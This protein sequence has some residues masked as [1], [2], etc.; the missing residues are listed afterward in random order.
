MVYHN[1]Y[2]FQWHVNRNVIRNEHLTAE[3]KVPVGYFTFQN[4]KWVFLNQK[5]T[6][7]KDLTEDKI[8]AIGETLELEEGKKVLLSGEDGGRVVLIS[9]ANK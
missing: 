4:G 5:L 8:I 6:G 9:M 7:L 2:L 1:Q 3:Q